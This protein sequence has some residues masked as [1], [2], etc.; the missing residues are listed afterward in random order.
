VGEEVPAGRAPGVGSGVAV[1]VKECIPQGLK[2]RF[3]SGEEC[4]G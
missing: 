1:V 4:P 2:P 3:V